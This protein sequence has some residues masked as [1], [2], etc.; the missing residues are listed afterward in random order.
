MTILKESSLLY[1]VRHVAVILIVAHAVIDGQR[2][3][4]YADIKRVFYNDE[5]NMCNRSSYN[6]GWNDL[7]CVCNVINNH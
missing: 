2:S 4:G 6:G 5:R 1:S 3:E 7:K